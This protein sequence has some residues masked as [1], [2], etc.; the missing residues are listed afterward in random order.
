[1]GIPG[2]GLSYSEK[3]SAGKS[4]AGL[5]ADDRFRTNDAEQIRMS[6]REDSKH[7]LIGIA[8]IA[9]LIAIAYVISKL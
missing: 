7:L 3:L 9:A 8:F 2:T 5:Q 4:N 6:E 1:V